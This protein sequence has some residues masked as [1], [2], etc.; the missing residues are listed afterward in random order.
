MFFP[1]YF[2]KHDFLS[3]VIL[4]KFGLQHGTR[5]EFDFSTLRLLVRFVFF[6]FD[7][8][9]DWDVVLSD[10]VGS[11]GPLMHAVKS[12][13][14]CAKLVPLFVLV[15]HLFLLVSEPGVGPHLRI[16]ALLPIFLIDN[17]Q[18]RGPCN[19]KGGEGWVR[20]RFH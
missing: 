1:V 10:L 19:V 8:V 13:E 5:I 20:E 4:C 3:L 7:Y 12:T 6:D 11:L 14:N 17:L 2:F 15:K 9:A 18:L 16:S